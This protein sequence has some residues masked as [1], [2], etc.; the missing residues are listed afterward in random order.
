MAK[1]LSVQATDVVLQA[2]AAGRNQPDKTA[3]LPHRPLPAAADVAS[4]PGERMVRLPEVL[5]ITGIG[6]TTLLVMV[7]E[8]RFPAPLAITPRIRGWRL[9]AVCQFLATLEEA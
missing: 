6:R 5:K 2:H 1:P 4:L 8:G 3:F 9:S 7:R